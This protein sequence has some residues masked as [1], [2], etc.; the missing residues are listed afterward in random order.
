AKLWMQILTEIRNRGVQDILIA[1]VDGLKGFADAIQAVYPNTEGQLCIVHMVRNSLA[2][3]SWKDRK[4]VA[5]DLKLVYRAATAE[6]GQRHLEEFET[7]WGSRYPS[8]AKMWQR[9][10]AGIS[11]LFAYPQEIR[12]AIYTTNVAEALT[13][14]PRQVTYT[15]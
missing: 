5:A 7:K 11:P 10:W 9:H 8:I 2:Y 6:Q 1:C 3:V 14:T 13:M 4:Q 12:R 15:Q